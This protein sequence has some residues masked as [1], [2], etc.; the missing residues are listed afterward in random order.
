MKGL[1]GYDGV[2]VNF[3]GKIADLV[4]LSVLWLIFSLPLVTMGAATTA[5]YHAVYKSMRQ[6]YGGIWSN[7]WEGFHSNFK[8]STGI[9]L[10]LL[11]LYAVLGASAYSAYQL[12]ELDI[13]GVTPLILVAIATAVVTM[14]A[15]YLLPS[16]ARFTAPTK[17]ILKSCI[18]VALINLFWSVALL[19]VLVTGVYLTFTIPVGLMVVPGLGMYVS[20]MILE[21]ILPKY[22]EP[23]EEPKEE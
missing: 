22:A 14:W 21:Y 15:V 2:L 13:S 6:G 18:A 5:M 8:Q 23:Q 12:L 3:F 7:F 19:A 17:Q 20:S 1:F 11:G 4:C 16:V 9:W 10:I